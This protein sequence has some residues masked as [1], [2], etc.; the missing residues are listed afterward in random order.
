MDVS[1]YRLY[2]GDIHN[3]NELGYAQGSLERSY[4][5][6]RS[7][8]DFYAF[9]P[10]GQYADGG[11]PDGYPVVNDN[12][13]RIQRAAAKNN[14]PGIFTCFLGYEWHSSAW[15]HVHVIQ[16]EDGQHQH[17]APT[18]ADL[19]AHFRGAE[20]IL[21]PHHTAY[22]NGVDWELFDESLSPLVE[23]FSEHG[24]S[25]RDI[26]L[27]PMLGHSGG[28]GGHQFTAQHGLAL[29]KRFGF[30]AGTD[31]HD[32]YPGGY[33]LGITGVWATANDRESIFEALR[34]R[35]TVACSGDRVEVEFH[36]GASPMGSVVSAAD[37]REITYSVRGWDFI[38]QIELVRDNVPVHVQIPDYTTSQ[39]VG[40]S[41]FYQNSETPST[42]SGD[43]RYRLRFEWGWG[44]MKGYQVY[45][46][47]GELEVSGGRIE[48]LV[49]C[50]TSDPFDEERRKVA[51]LSG[52]TACS[53]KS[54]T[55]RG[56]VFTTRNGSTANSA[57]DALC[58][59]IVG[60][61][62]TR[63]T[64]HMRCESHK[65]LLA[66]SSDFP[67][68]THGGSKELTVTVGD[69]LRGRQG[70]RLDDF[71]TWVVAHRAVPE[72]LY[73]MRGSHSL[74]GIDALNANGEDSFYYLRVTQEN[75]QMAWSSPIW[76]SG[77]VSG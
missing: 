36:C 59:E 13:E 70:H 77:R 73:T 75:G 44:P 40:S 61:E 27:H 48:Q 57:N 22:V 54:H 1:D 49:P 65:S 45:D 64:L 72:S 8:L 42:G 30:T 2:W 11:V 29:G 4:D 10:H 63:L 16:V 56:G 55:S 5:I 52:E 67:I 68:S 24:C 21:V 71:P 37:A 17:F 28:P 32:G 35:R 58:V 69:L 60:D 47:E 31:N 39:G 33:G 66:T 34:S 12:W 46:W 18:L 19:Q 25:E 51:N 76:V 15:G 50:F 3:H 53:W 43:R 14:T 23:I 74:D 9:T 6:A 7:H 62:R 38:K 26:G 41:A 20:A